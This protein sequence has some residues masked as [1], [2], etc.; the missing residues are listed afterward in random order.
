[1]LTILNNTISLTKKQYNLPYQTIALNFEP[2]SVVVPGRIGEKRSI[3]DNEKWTKKG[4]DKNEDTESQ[5]TMQ[6][7]VYDGCAKYQN[8]SCSGS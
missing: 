8:P 3:G 4:N 5:Y 7:V 6:Q 2:L 1:M